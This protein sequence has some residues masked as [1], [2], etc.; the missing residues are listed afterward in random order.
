M[1]EY[2]VLLNCDVDRMIA[3]CYENSVDFVAQGIRPIGP[4][5]HWSSASASEMGSDLWFALIPFVIVSSR[6]VDKMLK[7]RLT[8]AAKLATGE[9]SNWPYCE[10]FLPTAVAQLPGS[11]SWSIDRLVDSTLLRFRPCFSIR[12]PRL[13]KTE[14]LA[15]PVMSGV[16]F[17]KAF[18]DHNPPGSYY[19]ADGRLHPE[20]QSEKLEDLQAVLGDQVRNQRNPDGTWSVIGSIDLAFGKPATQSSHSIWSHGSSAAADAALANRDPLPHDFAFHTGIDENPWWQVDLLVLC[21]IERVEIINRVNES[22]RFTHFRID[23]SHDGEEWVTCFTKLDNDAVSSDP[24][25]PTQCILK[26]QVHA[27]YLRITQLSTSFMHLRK[28][29]V[30]GFPLMPSVFLKSEPMNNESFASLLDEP[31]HYEKLAATVESIVHGRVFGRGYDSYNIDKLA[32]LAAAI[33][34]GLYATAHMASAQ[35]FP[36]AGSVHDYAVACAPSSGMVLEFGVFSGK[37]INRIASQMPG[38]R[39]YG[40]DSFEGLPETWRPGFGQGAFRRADLPA[41]VDNVDLKVGW[42]DST[43]PSFVASNPHE[44]LALLHVDCDLYSSTKTIFAYLAKRIVPGTI[45]VFD[46]YFNYPEW[47]LH[48]YKA[49]QELRLEHA[50]AYDYIGIV[51]SHQQVVVRVINVG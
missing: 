18:I 6:A 17:I 51:P 13:L 44:P 35:R 49:F 27:R 38:R 40:F 25:Y 39:V 30:L 22:Q 20:L 43:L 8:L 36:D 29:R 46:E 23:V 4:N 37:S 41:V 3:D 31:T 42:F 16:R 19:M 45:I 10:A 33:D 47:R 24:R 5:D 48:E 21:A 50:I 14:S 1:L 34:S 9:I 2:D 12:D 11:T 32:F 28:V 7:A 15:H 26:H